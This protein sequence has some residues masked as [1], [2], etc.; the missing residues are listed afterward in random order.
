V[1]GINSPF[2][3]KLHNNQLA[4]KNNLAGKF[5]RLPIPTGYEHEDLGITPQNPGY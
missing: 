1:A 3:I 4:K 5:Y 2:Y